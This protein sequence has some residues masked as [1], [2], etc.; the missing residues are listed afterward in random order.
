MKYF[1]FLAVAFMTLMGL[2]SPS[3]AQDQSAQ[4]LQA[5]NT[6]YSQKNYDQAIRYYQAATQMNAN[7]WQAYQGL[8]G[9]YYAKGDNSNA[10]KNYQK[11]LDINPNNPQVSQFVTYLKSQSPAPALSTGNG[12]AAAFQPVVYATSSTKNFEL[13]VGPGIAI[14]S[15]GSEVGIGGSLSGFYM[16]D[17]NLSLGGSLH[18]YTYSTSIITVSE[19]ETE[20]S[21][22][23]NETETDSGTLNALEVIATGKYKFDGN[24]LVPYLIGGIG[25]V[26]LMISGTDSFTYDSG[27]PLFGNSNSSF[28]G[29]EIDPVI[30]GG[31]GVEFSLGKDMNL[32]GEARVD[33]V[34]GDGGTAT[35][36]PVDAG[37]SFDL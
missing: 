35:F 13:S 2:V 24:G 28:S 12:N 6:F 11:S 10:L 31:G 26:D 1:K 3:G 33:L 21:T 30:E 22:I 37:L 15:N 9:C 19:Y 34:I 36:I 4:Y 16:L 20:S 32:F 18:F 25:L 27:P 14:Y 23:G 7:S 8:G 29:S 5:G 17:K